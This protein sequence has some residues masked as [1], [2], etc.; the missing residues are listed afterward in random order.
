MVMRSGRQDEGISCDDVR[1]S[2]RREIPINGH[3][4]R[5]SGRNIFYFASAGAVGVVAARPERFAGVGTFLSNTLKHGF[6][7]FGTER[8]VFRDAGFG[9]MLETFGGEG[10]GKAAFG[11]EGV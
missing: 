4:V 7:A 10:F 6:A 8:G 3:D 1:S 5:S 11:R 9:A 2:G